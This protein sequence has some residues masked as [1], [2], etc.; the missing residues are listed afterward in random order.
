MSSSRYTQGA[1]PNC[2]S[3]DAYTTYEDGSYC[4]SCGYT[5]KEKVDEMDRPNNNVQ[6][7]GC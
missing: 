6:H 1:C 5:T 3:S 4:F 7:C 2:N